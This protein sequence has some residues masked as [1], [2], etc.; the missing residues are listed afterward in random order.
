[1]ICL[2]FDIEEFD[3]P[4]EYGKHL[5]EEEQIAISKEG[6]L[7]VLEVLKRH[8]IRAT[9][10]CTAF[11]AREQPGLIRRIAEEGHEVASHGFY[12]S[13][14][15]PEHLKASKD[16]LENVTG[17]AVKGFRMARMMQEASDREILKAGYSYNSSLNP[18]FLPGRYNHLRSPRTPFMQNGVWQLPAS[19]TPLWRIPLFWLSLHHL[20]LWLYQWLCRRTARHDNY[21]NIY[22][23]PWEF[24]DLHDAK[25]FGLPFYLSRRSGTP[26]IRRLDKLV[27]CLKKHSFRFGSLSE[28]IR[29]AENAPPQ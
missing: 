15:L 21:L 20:P 5:S 14:F 17:Q 6:T 23:H 10:F 9:F 25:K 28:W 3:A 4:L 1:M 19:V 12:H 8:D 24:I 11:F 2:G 7:H 29:Q 26:M 18:T 16:L 13:C 22:F 27:A